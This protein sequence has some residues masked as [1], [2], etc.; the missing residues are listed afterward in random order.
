MLA[1]RP[2]KS[3][4][5]AGVLALCVGI[6]V[7]AWLAWRVH[8][9][10]TSEQNELSAVA[11]ET[12][13][14]A[15]QGDVTAQNELGKLYLNGRGVP[16]DYGRA[17]RWFRKAAEQGNPKAQFNLGQAYH[18]GE[19]VPKDDA[20]AVQWLRKSADQADT[21]AQTALGYVYLH[22][23]GVPQGDAQA[24]AWYRRAAEHGYALAQQALGWM[25]YNGRGV[26]KNYTQAAAWYQKA[27]DQGDPVAQSSLGY[28]Y[29]YGV[30]VERDSFA[31]LRWYRMAAAQGEPS[32]KQ[33]LSSLKPPDTTRRIELAMGIIGSVGGLISLL[34]LFES[35]FRRKMPRPWLQAGF[36]TLG[37]SLLANAV[38]SFYALAHDIR[39]SPYHDAFHVLRRTLVAI[40]LIII[41]TVVLPAKKKPEA[42][43]AAAK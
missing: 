31:A 18:F 30:G 10:R 24:I 8:T 28:M 25:Y 11:T 23:E 5:K 41:C 36:A 26:Q 27:A 40:A 14:R 3:S 12:R 16:K 4:T 43:P 7:S 20:E 15:E 19:G 35:I 22:G 1:S 38:L 32:A 33:F 29:A 9:Q 42:S 21:H 6:T 37:V 2:M 17:A 39:Y 34:P 13:T